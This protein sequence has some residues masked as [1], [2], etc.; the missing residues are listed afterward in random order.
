MKKFYVTTP[1]YYVNAKP[2]LGTLYST[3]L[4]DVAARWHRF[5]GDEVFFLTG[6]DEHGQKI[7]DQAASHQMQPK[8]FVDSM[9]PA[10]KEAWER[11]AISYDFFIRTT[12]AAHKQAVTRWIEQLQAQGDI[13]KAVYEGLY[14]TPCETFVTAEQAIEV[15]GQSCCPSCHRGLAKIA[16]E[17]YFFRL[18][19]YQ[20]RL[21][22]FY[23]ENPDFIMPKER[24][25]EIL[26]FVRGGLRDL[27][28]S[29]RSV[30]WGIPF[31]GDP[32][33]TVYVWGD[34]L[35]N[36]VSALGFLQRGSKHSDKFSTF[37][38]ADLQ[39]MAKDIVKF[40]GVYFPAFLMAAGVK[41]A[42]QLLVHG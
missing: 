34:A 42:K 5:S 7:A 20:D 37:W 29:R 31:P 17:N 41:P 3:L 1:L 4:A 8:A 2:H 40:H 36:Y 24:T 16:E 10:F 27:S 39:V 15:E 33:H 9:I 30:E 28:I 21:L 22:T 18:S 32:N 35:M 6:T 19:A 11:Y 38:P 26:S 25:N 12:D 14:C 23:Q 13:Y